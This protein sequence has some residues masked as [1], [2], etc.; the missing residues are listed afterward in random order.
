MKKLHQLDGRKVD[1][2]L[3]QVD[4]VLQTEEGLLDDA[5]QMFVVPVQV[6]EI[7]RVGLQVHV[8]EEKTVEDNREGRGMRVSLE[9]AGR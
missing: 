5:D 3:H 4:L 9:F 2:R 1:F 6:G 7:G 8:V